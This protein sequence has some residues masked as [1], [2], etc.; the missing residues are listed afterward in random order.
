MDLNQ[1][2]K[3]IDA[4]KIIFFDVF[5]TL[6][7]R[8]VCQG[9]DAFS[10]V[11][12][13]YNTVHSSNLHFAKER[14]EAEALARKKCKFSEVNIAE[15]YQF[16]PYTQMVRNELLQ[17]ELEVEKDICRPYFPMQQLYDYCV[18]KHKTIYIVSDM[19]LPACSIEQILT[20]NGYAGY[21][22]I[23]SSCDYRV[24]KWENGDLFNRIVTDENLTK[25][26]ILHIG[27]D[28]IADFKMAQHQGIDAYLIDEPAR[29][30]R[31]HSRKHS[32]TYQ[33]MEKFIDDSLQ[34]SDDTVYQLGYEVFGPILYGYTMWLMKQCHSL[35]LKK[36][37][38]FSRD[39]YILKKAFDLFKT[40]VETIYFYTSRKALIVPLMHFYPTA[41]E[42]LQCYKSWDRQFSWQYV[43]NRFNIPST[44]YTPVLTSNHINIQEPLTYSSLLTS[45]KVEVIFDQ[46]KEYWFNH[47]KEQY[48]LL[49]QYMDEKQFDG[50]V[51][52]ID[53]GA[54]CSIESA[55]DSLL[56]KSKRQVSPYYLYVHTEK[57]NT[58][59]RFKYLDSSSKNHQFHCLLRFCYMFLELILAAPHGTISGYKQGE[60]QAEP[61]L[62]RNEY[63]IPFR[64]SSEADYIARLQTGAL[65]FVK[66][67]SSGLG[68]YIDISCEEALKNFFDFG[69]TPNIKDLEIWGNFKIQLDGYTPLINASNEHISIIHPKMFGKNMLSSV[70]PSG[71]FVKQT[72]SRNLMKLFYNVYSAIK[73]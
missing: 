50:R 63:D 66:D 9:R 55:L 47:S 62:E 42:F 7:K 11:E 57:E 17:L 1:I 36:L 32:F 39:G 41:K 56:Q 58:K 33:C 49:L 10:L 25:K 35:K 60:N 28:K 20:K 22:R 71:F 48:K 29:Q 30:S 59:H 18:Q 31:Y 16:L 73:K 14:Q 65:D 51:G 5:D 26:D 68:K 13:K 19:Y 4:H 45:S 46:I 23:Y 8:D 2:K 52:I 54:G 21:C 70:W 43:F 6:L 64:E 72:G 37:F 40:D 53:M 15:I 38:F 44:I 3:Q 24:T 12:K 61:I 34:K 69:L 67:F 27:N